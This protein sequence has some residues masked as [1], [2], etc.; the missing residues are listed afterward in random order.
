LASLGGFAPWREEVS[1]IA[2]KIR[3]G[4]RSWNPN[5]VS[6]QSELRHAHFSRLKRADGEPYS[7]NDCVGVGGEAL[8]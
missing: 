4:S 5:G 1:G 7:R 3:K 8:E 2:A 6:G